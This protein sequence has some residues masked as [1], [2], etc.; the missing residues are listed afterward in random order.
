MNIVWPIVAAWLILALRKPRALAE[1]ILWCLALALCLT[2]VF[3]NTS[4]ASSLIALL[5]LMTWAGW[6][7]FKAIR[8]RL[9]AFAPAQIVGVTLASAT[10][11]LLVVG[12]GGL[13]MA[14]KRW[15][16][17]N[18]QFSAS[19]PRLLAAQVCVEMLPHAGWFGF[20]PGTFRTA[21]P[22]FN[23]HTG[24]ETRGVWIYAHEDYLQTLVEWGWMGTAPFAVV[25]FGG[26]GK[27]LRFLARNRRR[28][29]DRDH[30]LALAGVG[31][32]LAV[33]IHALGDFPFQV[34]SIQ[35]Y[36]AVFV[37]LFWSCG[38]TWGKHR[39]Q[40]SSPG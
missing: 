13:D 35:L 34:P 22:F 27:A 5:M 36:A 24:P 4:R 29:S 12:F 32:M 6:T 31:G 8:G 38:S 15:S 40:A 10:L 37:G 1:K 30:A 18:K 19:N 7:L 20:G 26:I 25:I 21:F 9:D 23:K 33:L 2:G 39:N 11:L 17:V 16:D 3:A 14:W 28:L